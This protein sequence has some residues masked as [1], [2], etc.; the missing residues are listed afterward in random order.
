MNIIL[1]PSST[2]KNCILLFIACRTQKK[3]SLK[4]WIFSCQPWW[5]LLV[6]L[7]DLNVHLDKP[8]VI[9]FLTLL[10]SFGLTYFCT[11]LTH[12]TG[13]E[14]GL[15]LTKNLFVT[16]YTSLSISLF[17]SPC[18]SLTCFWLPFLK[19][20]SITTFG[21]SSLPASLSQS[22]SPSS[23][24]DFSSLDTPLCLPYVLTRSVHSPPARSQ[25]YHPWLSRMI[26]AQQANFRT[27]RRKLP[28][29]TSYRPSRSGHTTE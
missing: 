1:L 14:L 18:S 29:S 11:P 5:L 25:P 28:N 7:G 17:S 21:L 2:L 9:D 4:N 12:N 6:F 22:P 13:H 19:L 8:Q 24:E 15:I 26:Y 16:L 27:A 3:T 10:T 20:P 23:S